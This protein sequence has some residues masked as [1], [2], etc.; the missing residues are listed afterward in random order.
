[1]TGDSARNPDKV[2]LRSTLAGDQ[3]SE[4]VTVGGQVIVQGHHLACEL[5]H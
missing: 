5:H 3:L 1:V 4:L 2:A